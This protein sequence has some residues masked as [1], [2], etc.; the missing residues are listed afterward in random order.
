MKVLAASW[1]RRRL[2]SPL[3]RLSAG[4]KDLAGS[5]QGDV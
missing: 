2:T 4:A 5:W 1:F 3:R